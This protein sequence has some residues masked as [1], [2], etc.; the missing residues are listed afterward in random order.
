MSR[1]PKPP[2]ET[3]AQEGIP[4]ISSKIPVILDVDTGIDDAMAIWY[5]LKSPRL[6]VV[7]LTTCFGNG[8]I[9]T[10][11]RNTLLAVELSGRRVPVYQGAAHPLASTGVDTAEAF[12][13]A[14]GLGNAHLPPVTTTPEDVPA[15]EFLAETLRRGG[16]TVITLA[17]LTNL[18]LALALRPDLR[19][20]VPR[21]VAMGGAVLCPGNVT[22]VAEAN[23]WGDPEAAALVFESGIPLTMVGLDVTHQALL[24]D[25]HGTVTE[26]PTRPYARVLAE[27]SEFY[28]AAY[29]PGGPVGDRSAPLHDPLAVAVA[30][31]PTLVET[32]ALGVTIALGDQ[33]TRGMTVADT[34]TWAPVPRHP[35]DVALGV[36]AP[37]FVGEFVSRL[38]YRPGVERSEH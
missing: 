1:C 36:D 11:T 12:H 3:Y 5:A 26:D 24:M 15:A 18:A 37:R 16:I 8:G 13:G 27:A 7:A 10:T 28:L 32:R 4:V 38:G 30:E 2:F 22:P 23:I 17:R 34:R 14:N 20:R 25:R 33:A 19:N 6:D 29:N 31:D 9:D 21:I 35:V